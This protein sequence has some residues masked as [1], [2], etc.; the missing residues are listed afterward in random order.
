M[1]LG[2]YVV[3]QYGYGKIRIG[4]EYRVVEGGRDWY[5]VKASGTV[6]YAPLWVFH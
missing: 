6:F 3:A 1:V 5:K 4:T 2:E